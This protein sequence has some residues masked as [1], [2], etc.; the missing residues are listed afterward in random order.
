[1]VSVEKSL[2]S[3]LRKLCNDRLLCNFRY[4]KSFSRVILKCIIGRYKQFHFDNS[5][6]IHK[7]FT[8]Y[9][10]FT[11][12]SKNTADCPLCDHDYIAEKPGR[13]Y[14]SEI[15]ECKE[16]VNKSADP[17]RLGQPDSN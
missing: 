13:R 14:E 3:G 4:L 16:S 1:M 8:G 2:D 9:S 7:S 15:S 17:H 5:Q 10:Q 12:L 11:H 6:V